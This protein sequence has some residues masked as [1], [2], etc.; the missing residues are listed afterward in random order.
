MPNCLGIYIQ[1][2]IIKYAKVSKDHEKIKVDSFGIK[3][4]DNLGKAID[5]IVEETYSYKT[6]ISIN[7]SD[8][9]YNYFNIFALLNKKDLHKVISTEFDSYCSEKKFDANL[10]ETRYALVNNLEEKEKI[11]V[12]HIAA[13]KMQL[14]SEMDEFDGYKLVNV[15]PMP[16]TIPNIIKLD[17]KENAIIVNI[18][19]KTTITT[20][21]DEKIYDITTLEEGAFEILNRIN[22]K[23]NSYSKSYE[24]CKNTT[25]YTAEGQDLGEDTEGHLEDIMP[26]LYDI[27]GHI[28]KK[29][30]ETLNKIDKVY[31]TGTASCINNIDLYF[32]EYLTEVKCEILKPYFINNAKEISL[33]DYIEVNSAIALG[34]QGLG[35]GIEGI[36]FKRVSLKDKI[37]E[38]TK[39]EISTKKNP[40]SRKTKNNKESFSFDFSGSLQKTEVGLL[41]GVGGLISLLLIYSILV[42]LISN[43]IDKKQKEVEESISNTN[44]QISLANADIQKIRTKKS[45]YTAMI[46]NLQDLNDRISEANKVRNSIPNLLNSIMFS[47]PKDVQI[48]SIENTTDRHIVIQ[49][50]AAQY[51]Q[52]GYLI[53]IIKNNGYLTNVVPNSGTKESDVIKVT[54]EGD[55]P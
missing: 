45:E 40:N 7:L 9:M 21:I 37:P 6:P 51:E 31:I 12:I 53:S 2:N 17:K 5:Q 19:D 50:K 44:S 27:V 42:T 23:E 16:M 46:E 3:F 26:I 18:E 30:N 54:I 38:L 24:I 20:I 11:K 28:R 48:T 25:I 34:L 55:L 49:A 4:Y 1:K 35:E 43:Q 8:E 33:K 36:N 10:F 15:S 29:I 13:N 41:R 52:L 32:Q 14:N 22:A 39:M 47:M